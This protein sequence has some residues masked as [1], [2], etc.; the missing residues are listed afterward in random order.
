VIT[1]AVLAWGAPRLRDLPWRHTRDPWK[2]LVSEVMLQ[3]TQVA[4]VIERWPRVLARFPTPRACARAPLADVLREW[5]G[6][7]YPRRARNLHAAATAIESAGSFPS[8]LAGL[9]ALPGVG[10]YTARAVQAFAFEA[11]AAVVDT[12]IARVYARLAGRRLTAGEVQAHA[13]AALPAGDAWVWNQCLMDLGAL[14]CRPVPACGECPLARQCAWHARSGSPDPAAG[15]AG[16]SRRQ[17]RFEG[18]D[19]QARGRLLSVLIGGPVDASVVAGVMQRDDA[20]GARLLDSLVADGL[21]E[22]VD[23]TV[24]LP[25]G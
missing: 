6:L 3:Q 13:D 17:A 18:S 16:V 21:V 5:Q 22:R 24:R 9:L 25:G 12:N 4:R 2:V 23:A 14:V 8:D 7:G 15:S 1:G 20:T 10:P 11:D 19:R